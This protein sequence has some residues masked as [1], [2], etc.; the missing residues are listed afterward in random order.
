VL[1][2]T[3]GSIESSTEF[4]AVAEEFGSA[5]YGTGLAGYLR[6]LYNQKTLDPQDT[7]RDARG[8]PNRVTRT[9][10]HVLCE[11]LTGALYTVMVK[12]H[13]ALKQE[14][15][16]RENKSEFSISGKALAVGAERFKRMI[17]RA[18]D[19]LP[20]GEIS[21]A[22]YGR[23]ILAAD[24][25]SHPEDG[26]EREWLRQ[27]FIHRKMIPGPRS[28][29]VETHLSDPALD[30]LD[31]QDLLE[32]DWAAYQFANDH[33]DLLFIPPGIP[34]Q[35]ERRMKVTKRYYHRTG[36][37]EVSECLFK[38]WW[39]TT[40]QNQVGDQFPKARR[41]AVGTTLAIDW[42]THTLRARLTSDRTSFP[43]EGEE[44][45]QDRDRFLRHLAEQDILRASQDALGPDGRPLRAVI[46]AED[47]HGVMR[48]KSMARMLHIIGRS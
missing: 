47:I 28:L 44:Q 45:L 8:K 23:A 32:S 48:V 36:Q 20:P 9:E 43:D 13:S 24:Q 22:D 5:L 40:E 15:A 6:N 35:V 42:E 3:G 38:V 33:R 11:V 25:A 39:Y 19:Y 17:L 7:T 27:E 46:G 34:F 1:D 4:S 29:E 14:L 30:G 18:L 37:Q 12:L 16:A 10:P 31:L 21:F 26:Q 41:I 2:R